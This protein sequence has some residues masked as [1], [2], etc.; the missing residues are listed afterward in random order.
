M[1][2]LLLVLAFVS[3]LAGTATATIIH[4]PGD[5][6][7]IQAGIAAVSAAGDTVLVACGTY[8]EH[9]I[10]MRPGIVL[11]SESGHPDCVTIDAQYGGRVLQ[12]VDINAQTRVEGFTLTGS[13]GHSH[14]GAVWCLSSSPTF[15]NMVFE[16]NSAGWGGGMYCEV[17]SAPSIEHCIFRGNYSVVGTCGGLCCVSGSSPTLTDV[18]FEGNWAFMAAGMY[19]RDSSPVLTNVVFSNNRAE[20][21]F[22]YPGGGM[23]CSNASPVLTYV[24]FEGNSAEYGAALYCRD[25]S[26]P[27]LSN[28]TVSGNT[29]AAG[30][31]VYCDDSSPVFENT[32]IAFNGI[33]QAI[34]CVGSSSPLLTCCDVYGNAG[35]DWV[36]CIA[37]QFGANGNISEDPLFCGDLNPDEPLSLSGG[38]PCAPGGSPE[39]GLIGA[40]G[41]GCEMT[42]VGNATWGSIKAMYRQGSWRKLESP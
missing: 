21:P 10:T 38:S 39:C 30:F 42:L 14:G 7:T 32:I 8:Y 23:Y 20:A 18:T 31:A 5:Q 25:G 35:G 3:I 26:N 15:S 33:G 34:Y 40:W 24:T 28:V 13:G 12:C 16:N 1:S 19:C 36:G 17:S 11:R 27:T 41:V 22:G 4:V 2:K 37:G 29:S 6:P 9:D